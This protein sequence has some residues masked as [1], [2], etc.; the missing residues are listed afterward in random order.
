M[1]EWR[2]GTEE[3]YPCE[4]VY[5]INEGMFYMKVNAEDEESAIDKVRKFYKEDI[6]IHEVNWR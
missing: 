1:K 4:V 6:K 5:K 2:P 3:E